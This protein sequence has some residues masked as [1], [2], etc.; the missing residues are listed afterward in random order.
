MRPIVSIAAPA[1]YPTIIVIGRDGYDRASGSHETAGSAAALAARCRNRRRGRSAAFTLSG[2]PCSLASIG[3]RF[4][5]RVFDTIGG[6]STLVLR[7]TLIMLTSPSFVP[8]LQLWIKPTM[9]SGPRERGRDVSCWPVADARVADPSVRN[10]SKFRHQSQ[11]RLTVVGGATVAPVR[12]PLPRKA[13]VAADMVRLPPVTQKRHSLRRRIASAE[14][15]NSS[16][17][18]FAVGFTRL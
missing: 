15:C 9:A 18:G 6:V 14:R 2:W 12:R 13:A 4:V 1:A 16:A 8:N 3:R 5:R 7:R 17:L 10:L 11:T